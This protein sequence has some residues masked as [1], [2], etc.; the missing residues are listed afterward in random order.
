MLEAP[1]T[2]VHGVILLRTGMDVTASCIS[3]LVLLAAAGWGSQG[4]SL[5]SEASQPRFLPNNSDVVYIHQD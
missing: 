5:G 2:A 1:E 3:C 4:W